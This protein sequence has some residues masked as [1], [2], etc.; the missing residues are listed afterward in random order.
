MMPILNLGADMRRREFL[1][2]VAGVGLAWPRVT[3][4]QQN[5]KPKRIVT[6]NSSTPTSH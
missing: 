3:W 2:A 1:G 5:A 4:A 6:L